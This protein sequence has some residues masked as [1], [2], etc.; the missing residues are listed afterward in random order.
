MRLIL[1][2]RTGQEAARAPTPLP[3]PRP[4]E[5][6]MALLLTVTPARQM[7]SQHCK[8]K[9]TFHSPTADFPSVARARGEFYGLNCRWILETTTTRKKESLWPALLG[10]ALLCGLLM[11]VFLPS[12]Q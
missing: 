2:T 10:T 12:S 1:V 6:R 9:I 5:N 7:Q 8:A 4:W 3:Q 11:A